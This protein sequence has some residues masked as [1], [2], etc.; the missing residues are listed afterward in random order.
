MLVWLSDAGGLTIVVA[1]LIVSISFL[2]LRRK[3]PNMKRPYKVK[4][5]KLVGIIAVLMCVILTIMYLPGS[6]AALV[7]PYEWGI[8]MAWVVLGGVFFIWAKIS[9]KVDSKLEE[10]FFK[11]EVIDEESC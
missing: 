3:E 10:E 6:P 4:H 5:G 9:N 11:E 7:W 8:V 1:Y 2:A